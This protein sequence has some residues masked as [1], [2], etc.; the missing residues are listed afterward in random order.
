MED[1]AATTDMKQQAEQ[2]SNVTRVEQEHT[3]EVPGCRI[4]AGTD[5]ERG[6]FHTW[7]SDYQKKMRSAFQL[8]HLKLQMQ[9]EQ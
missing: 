6:H 5:K 2:N 3:Q 8:T 1:K 7:W 4:P 9:G